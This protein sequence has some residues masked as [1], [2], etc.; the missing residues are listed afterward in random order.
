MGLASIT[1]NILTDTGITPSGV[2]SGTLGTGQVAYGSAANTIAGSNNLFWDNANGRLGVGTNVPSTTLFVSGIIGTS[3]RVRISAGRQFDLI[4]ASTYLD[5]FDGSAGQSI[6]RFFA[7]RNVG[8][9]FTTDPAVRLGVSGD[10]LLLGSGNTS[11]TTALTV[12]N[13][14]S[15]SMLVVQNHGG[16]GIGS[17]SL[18]EYALRISKNITGAAN[19]F[20]IRIDGAIQTDVTSSARGIEVTPSAASGTT[21][22]QLYYFY[23]RQNTFTGTVTN[24]SGFRVDNNLI[25]ATNN[26]GF[27]GDISAAAGRWNLFM[28]GTASNDMAGALLIGITTNT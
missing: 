13:S 3:N 5:L 24:Q 4:G 18:T 17:T 11:A 23:A 26:Y 10:T 28:N 6:I 20:G 25:G 16:V 19:S 2:I 7:T 12:Q 27:F 14:D 21:L 22:S 1:N 9:G 8:I 15:T